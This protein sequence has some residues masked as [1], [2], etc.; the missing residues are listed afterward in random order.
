[1]GGDRRR[2]RVGQHM[3]HIFYYQSLDKDMLL[4]VILLVHFG[5]HAQ[6]L[7]FPQLSFDSQA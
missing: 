1:M 7:I 4:V 5:W 3:N 2:E 6:Y